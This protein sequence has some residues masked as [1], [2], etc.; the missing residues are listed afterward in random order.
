MLITSLHLSSHRPHSALIT[1]AVSHSCLIDP[2]SFSVVEDTRKWC[3]VFRLVAEQFGYWQLDY[4]WLET[5]TLF[6]GLGT[7]V[8][9]SGDE[10]GLQWEDY[11]F[12]MQNAVEW[13][14][15]MSR[16][17]DERSQMHAMSV[18][19][20][21]CEGMSDR[22]L[23]DEGARWIL[24]GSEQ[25]QR[26]RT[27]GVKALYSM[28]ASTT[29][30]RAKELVKQGLS[31]RNGMIAFGRIRERFGKT[32]GVAKLT[33]VFQFQWTSSD[34]LEDKWLR[35]LKLMR[36]VNMTSLG[37]DARE[38]LTIAGL[39]K[40]KERSL[41]QHLRLRAPQ[42]W[43]VLCASVD[44]YLRTTV[45]ASPTP[46][47]IGAVVST[48]ACCGKAG[49][50]KSK[51]RLRNVKCSNCGKTGHVKKMC[52]QREKSSP[53]SSSSKG[54]GKG[55][56]NRSNTDKCYCCGQPG[57]RRPD[58]PHRNE[59]CSR[60]GKRGHLVQMCQS[61]PGAKA[62]A[63]AVDLDEPD[64]E[65]K[66]IQHVWALS[67][68][69]KSE[70]LP[71][72]S[73]NLLN[74]IMD[75]GAEEHVVSLDDWRRLGKPLLKPARVRL[76][77]A[78]GDD[79]GV[80]GSLV[81]RGWCDDKLV[82]LTALVADR[83]TRSLCS[84]T[85]LVS[86]GYRLEMNPSHSVLHHSSDGSVRLRRCGNRDFLSIR[87]KRLREINAITFTTLKREVQSLKSE[88]RALRTGHLSTSD[89]RLPWT[90]E[91]KHRHEANG[92]AEYDNRCEI[93]VKYSGISRHPRRG[94]S[95]SC[96]FDYASV[97]FKESD[98]HVTVLTG[99]G[100]RCEC[101][102]RVVPRKGQ[103][104]KDLEHFLAVMRARYPNLQVRSDNE[105]ALK[106]VLK[107]ACEQVHLE[108]S[109]TRLETPAFNGRG[110]NSV[111]TMKEMIQRQKDAVF[112]LGIVF[113]IKH[114]L[115]ALLVRHSEW[116][117]NHLLRNDFIVEVDNRVIKTSPYESHT[118]NPAPNS[119]SFLNRILVGRRDDDDKQPRF[120]LAWFLGLIGG[121]DEV[122][123]LH[124]D[125]VQR[126]RGEWRV[127]PLDDPESNLR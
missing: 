94:Y 7:D 59:S 120:Q 98:D 17:P 79:M 126:H 18:L 111:R 96:A 109:N 75:S 26:D 72:D 1:F 103:R 23:V 86:A 11:L 2:H 62:N 58:C 66:E 61:D 8:H 43:T 14:M 88:L 3:P 90:P 93:F 113:S 60:C 15:V 41:E 24:Q 84:A 56:K 92:H 123:A 39:E 10:T 21:T 83:A 12:E 104:L 99:R 85:K 74:M 78:T 67:V 112:S 46:M 6:S 82:E 125:G 89:V 81:V 9:F 69:N 40:A 48:C 4:I 91:E 47:E 57:H 124:P 64:E 119:T 51:C 100:P 25:E 42:T 87:V 68:C 33:D 37:D 122:I 95:E 20:S 71:V 5:M 97:T 121:S 101:F 102:C 49:H 13:R 29:S 38:T 34:S 31:D 28:L 127:S 54:S 63:Q 52:R 45:D 30:G 19:L 76:R 27:A 77:S 50:E 107:D 105:E 118:G 16:G 80:S 117:L 65:C 32:A 55:G 116:I 106:H 110:E 35:W 70:T 114:P 44:Q 22:A 36:Q 73:G 108:Y 53:S 115:F